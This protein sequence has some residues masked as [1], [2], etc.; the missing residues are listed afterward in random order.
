MDDGGGTYGE[1]TDLMWSP[2]M[3][4]RMYFI[5]RGSRITHEYSLGSEMCVHFKLKS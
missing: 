2:D 5:T 3:E 4:V 1:T